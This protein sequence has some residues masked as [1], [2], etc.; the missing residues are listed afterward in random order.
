MKNKWKESINWI[1]I[2]WKGLDATE[3]FED[4]GHSEDARSLLKDYYV[5][6]LIQVI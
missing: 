6:D 2:P 3:S 1:V 4:V 5:G